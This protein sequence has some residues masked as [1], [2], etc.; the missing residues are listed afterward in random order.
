MIYSIILFRTHIFAASRG[1]CTSKEEEVSFFW[2]V[3]CFL[4]ITFTLVYSRLSYLLLYTFCLFLLGVIEV[5]E[6]VVWGTCKVDEAA[7]VVLECIQ[8]VVRFMMLL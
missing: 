6:A 1:A 8:M 2:T 7:E 4:S 3:V 5:D